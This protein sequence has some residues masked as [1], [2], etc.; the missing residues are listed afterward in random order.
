MT[1]LKAGFLCND[2]NMLDETDVALVGALFFDPRATFDALGHVAG[3]SASTA[4]R[5]LRRLAESRT[6][7]VV[8]EVSWHLFSQTYPVHAW[9]SVSGREHSAVARDIAQLPEAQH[10]ATLYGREPVFAT[11]HGRN[12]I[13]TVRVIDQIH[14]IDGVSAVYTLP[15]LQWAVKASGWNPM[16]LS[17][18][19]LE[20]AKEV[21]PLDAPPHLPQI[22]AT[23]QPPCTETE[24]AA[25]HALQRDGRLTA[26]E[27][28]GVIGTSIPTAQRL[29]NRLIDDGWFRPRV[30]CNLPA[31]GM[32]CKFLVRI[33]SNPQHT[34]SVLREI[35]PHPANRF[36]T[37]I[38]GDSDV[39]ATGVCRNRHELTTILNH[40][41]AAIH[42]LKA[43]QTNIIARDW[44]RYWTSIDADGN[45]GQFSPPT[46][47]PGN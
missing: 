7:R 35:S 28:S 37:Q 16:L 8:G 31:I 9:I 14:C 36:V 47:W 40:D 41:F 15:V 11:L 24:V 42:G 22:T 32:G 18:E 33:Q 39:F 25:L 45:L 20:R 30:E 10:V 21:L 34:E 17:G 5:R 29:I 46:L 44:K 2:E 6:I 19:H 23:T 3:V 13:D 43:T 4:S 12:D 27:L 1:D 26:T 38:A